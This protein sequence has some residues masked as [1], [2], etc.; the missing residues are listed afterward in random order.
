M[1]LPNCD[2]PFSKPLKSYPY[3]GS[4]ATFA[5]ASVA[6][7]PYSSIGLTYCSMS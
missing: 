7:I 6:V 2:F 5:A 1:L 3:V 4:A